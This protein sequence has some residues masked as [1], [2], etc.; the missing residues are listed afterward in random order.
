[1]SL[2]EFVPGGFPLPASPIYDGMS[3]LSDFV[4]ANFPLPHEPVSYAAVD[5]SLPKAP[6]LTQAD[7]AP[8]PAADGYP[9]AGEGMGCG[10]ASCGGG[11]GALD[12]ASL[13]PGSTFGISNTYLVGGALLAVILFSSMG[14][15][16]RRR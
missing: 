15:G 1:M 5:G 2:R 9:C 4:P 13:I 12:L 6:A 7:L 14:G 16:R 3:G 11:M 10:C 8:I